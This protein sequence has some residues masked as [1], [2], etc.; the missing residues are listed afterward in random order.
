[1]AGRKVVSVRCASTL[2]APPWQWCI[3]PRF[4]FGS[5]S[6]AKALVWYYA[7]Y[8]TTAR[9]PGVEMMS[10]IL[11]QPVTVCTERSTDQPCARDMRNT[12]KICT[13]KS[14]TCVIRK[15]AVTFLN[16]GFIDLLSCTSSLPPST[17][18]R[19]RILVCPRTSKSWDCFERSGGFPN[20]WAA[21]RHL[22]NR[23]CS[24]KSTKIKLVNRSSD[25]Q[26][27]SVN[28][29]THFSKKKY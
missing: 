7:P 20:D 15:L 6:T 10:N 21:V 8:S 13:H 22:G 17:T 1:M 24:N 26:T 19:Q 14:Y 16:L 29:Q 25:K 12:A 3:L 18:S 4:K 5:S 9:R 23:D 28:V 11:L 2:H 27:K